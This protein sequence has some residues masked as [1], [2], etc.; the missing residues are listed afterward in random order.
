MVVRL[1]V[2]LLPGFPGCI[3]LLGL[4]LMSLFLPPSWAHFT[5]PRLDQFQPNTFNDPIDNKDL[6]IFSAE[7][8]ASQLFF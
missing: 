8:Y 1:W 6:V 5:R 4:V 2:E 3:F 7:I